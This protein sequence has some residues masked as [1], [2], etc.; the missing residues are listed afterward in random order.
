MTVS[1]CN[2]RTAEEIRAFVRRRIDED[3]GK[4]EII[5]ELEPTKRAVYTGSLGFISLH[6]EME[7]NI[8]IRSLLVKEGRAWFQV[9]GGIVADSDPAAEYQETLDKAR[10]LIAALQWVG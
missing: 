6:G 7:L 4:E 5:E 8:L 9:G 2:C 10:A 1:D 3:A